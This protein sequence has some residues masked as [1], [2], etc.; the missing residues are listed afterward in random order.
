MTDRAA[1]RGH[2]RRALSSW[3]GVI[4]ARIALTLAVGGCLLPAP[5]AA[6]AEAPPPVPLGDTV[7]LYNQGTSALRHGRADAAEP[8][9]RSAMS[10]TSPRWMARI[11]YNLGNAHF[12]Q[13]EAAAR[14]SP[15]RAAALYRQ[16]LEDYRTAIRHDARDMDAIFNYEL[17]QQ[18][19]AAAE[20]AAQARAD[21]EESESQGSGQRDQPQSGGQGEQSQDGPRGDHSE[22]AASAQ[23]SSSSHGAGEQGDSDSQ[24]SEAREDG[25]SESASSGNEP[26]QAPIPQLA[27]GERLRATR[28]EPPTHTASDAD[29][30]E[31]GQPVSPSEALWIL[32]SVRDDEQRGVARRPPHESAAEAPVE[33]DW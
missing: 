26:G 17:T 4:A 21:A 7:D 22:E 1:Q 29:A 3:A 19:L 11:A 23:A 32:D 8:A 33:Q 28:D 18:R 24:A 27:P 10:S 6:A 15:Q 5:W 20:A 31:P 25:S 16:A 14:R 9:L 13:A 30:Q 12:R 2:I